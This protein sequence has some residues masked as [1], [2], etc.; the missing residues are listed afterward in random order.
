MPKD[1]ASE[2]LKNNDPD[3]K[4]RKTICYPYLSGRQMKRRMAHEVPISNFDTSI[5]KLR[6]NMSDEDVVELKDIMS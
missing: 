2:W 5:V 6:L 4:N 1:V 3:Y